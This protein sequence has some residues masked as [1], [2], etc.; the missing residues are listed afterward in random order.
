MGV[1]CSPHTRGWT[2][3]GE[4]L[5]HGERSCSPHTRGWTVGLPISPVACRSVP[6]TRGDG[7]IASEVFA[8]QVDVFPAHAGM[9]RSH[10][11]NWSQFILV[12]PAHAGM[13]RGRL[14]LGNPPDDVFPA[15]AGMDRGRSSCRNQPTMCSPHTRGWT[16]GMMDAITTCCRVPRTRGDGPGRSG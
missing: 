12:F 13:D 14:R 6:R 1:W 5:C 2:G 8:A 4:R 10:D 3:R 16:V 9:D 11:K 7:P 15:H